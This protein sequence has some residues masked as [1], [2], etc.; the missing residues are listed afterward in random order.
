MKTLAI[1]F[2]I[3]SLVLTVGCG[4]GPD[5]SQETSSSIAGFIDGSVVVDYVC[6]KGGTFVRTVSSL[7][8]AT[9]ESESYE[10]EV[11]LT[12]DH[13]NDTFSLKIQF[14][15]EYAD[16]A[17]DQCFLTNSYVFTGDAQCDGTLIANND[18]EAFYFDGEEIKGEFKDSTYEYHFSAKRGESMGC[19]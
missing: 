19:E 12:I 16:W 14:D 7:D 5:D 8:F 9:S 15:I 4:Q 2:S 17:P 10:G 18:E 13:S 1:T 11:E 6:V 3:L